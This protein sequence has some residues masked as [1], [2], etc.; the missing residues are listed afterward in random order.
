M[1]Q[2][3]S[4]YMQNR[5]DRGL[6]H[7]ATETSVFYHAYVGRTLHTSGTLAHTL[8]CRTDTLGSFHEALVD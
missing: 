2:N 1:V 3:D 4:I 6:A 7:Y 5:F 8:S